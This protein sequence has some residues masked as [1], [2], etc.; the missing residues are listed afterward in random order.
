M[1]DLLESSDYYCLGVN[2]TNQ[3]LE[4]VLHIVDKDYIISVYK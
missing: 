4:S 3:F 1:N 2:K